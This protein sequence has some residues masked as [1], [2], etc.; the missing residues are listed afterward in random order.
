MPLTTKSE[1]KTLLQIGVTD[2]SKDNLI[3]SLILKVQ[4]FII[5]RINN[6]FVP[7]VYAYGSNI[8]FASADKSIN[9]ANS[10]LNVDGLAAGND[11]IVLGSYQNGNKL[12][13]I[14]TI[15]AAKIVVNEVVTT[16]A[17][18]NQIIYI[19]RVQFTEDIK[20]VAAD[21]IAERFNKDRH[22]SSHSLG[23]HSETFISQKEIINAFSSW[24]K[25]QWT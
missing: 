13:S 10:L 15:A 14:A 18:S 25:I 8:S 4:D 21:F 17:S 5:R 12:F 7:D 24:K 11:I 2:T 19:Q 9:D 3:D 22:I 20:M 23:D 1:I 6:F 16:E